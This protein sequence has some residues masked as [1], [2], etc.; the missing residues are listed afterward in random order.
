ME[1][2][3]LKSYVQSS[4][5]G[6]HTRQNLK[7]PQDSVKSHAMDVGVCSILA[8]TVSGRQW[9]LSNNKR[10]PKVALDYKRSFVQESH[11]DFI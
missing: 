4:S 3:D 1:F 7:I 5:I 2:S 10:T 11:M 8:H 6:S 9:E